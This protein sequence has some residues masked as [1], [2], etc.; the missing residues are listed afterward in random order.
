MNT[1][2][3]PPPLSSSIAHRAHSAPSARATGNSESAA[4]T[5]S[6][7]IPPQGNSGSRRAISA[8]HR[9]IPRRLAAACTVGVLALCASLYAAPVLGADTDVVMRVTHPCG[10]LISNTAGATTSSQVLFGTGDTLY[11]QSFHTGDNS[12][13]YTL[14]SVVVSFTAFSSR[15]TTTLMAEVREAAG[16]NP[17][18]TVVATLNTPTSLPDGTVTAVDLELTAPLGHHA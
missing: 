17:G 9:T 3:P 2:P 11:A 4:P 1:T 13:G 7:L 18:S 14:Q 6:H 10:I 8:G 15:P 12:A 5:R 16:N